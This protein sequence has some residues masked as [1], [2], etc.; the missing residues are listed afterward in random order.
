[1][2]ALM[3]AL[4]A[5]SLDLSAVKSAGKMVETRADVW[6]EMMVVARAD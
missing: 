1:M 5:D 2:V 6:V 4:M 3:V